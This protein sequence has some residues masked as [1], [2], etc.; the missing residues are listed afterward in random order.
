MK[1]LFICSGNSKYYNISPF[2]KKQG[3]SLKKNCIEVQYYVI[4]KGG[5]IGYIINGL[6]LKKYLKTNKF[7]LIHAHYSLSGWTA[8]IGAGKIPVVL[9]LMGSDAYGK[10]L[11]ENKISLLSR[12][13]ILMTTCIQLFVQGIISKS[14]NIEKIVF[15]KD[16]SYILPNGVELNKFIP[17]RKIYRSQLGL[18]NKKKYILFLGCKENIRKNYH[19]AKKSYDLIKDN[20]VELIAPYPIKYEDVPKYIK[21]SNVLILTSFAEG[22]SN[23]VKEAMA[24]NCPIVSTNVGDA[25][26]LFKDLEGC[27]L[28]G[29]DSKEFGDKIKK[30]LDFSEKIG[31]TKGRERLI[32][33]GL[34]IETVAKNLVEIYY[35]VLKN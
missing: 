22:S 9:S 33:L 3:E 10:Y 2:V 12:I 7:D 26:W 18:E 24:C 11:A 20:N 35:K 6:K 16:I 29:F 4:N 14:K 1:I 21:S 8:V 27:Y 31:F 25:E 17:D 13:N 34:D 28:S 32:N 30:A 5:I 23:V 19:L 15:R